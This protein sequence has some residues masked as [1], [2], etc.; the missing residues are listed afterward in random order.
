MDDDLLQV[1]DLVPN[2]SQRNPTYEPHGQTGVLSF[3]AQSDE[4]VTSPGGG[5]Y[6]ILEVDTYGLDPY[7]LDTVANTGGGDLALTDAQVLDFANLI[8][9]QVAAG[10]TLEQPVI[11]DL[12]NSVAGVSGSGLAVGNSRASVNDILRI[13]SGEVYKIPAGS[14]VVRPGGE[15]PH[16]LHGFF[17]TP[18]N[19]IP[20]LTTGP[21]GR[22]GGS[23][24]Q[25]VMSP[26][27]RPRRCILRAPSLGPL[28]RG[29]LPLRGGLPRPISRC[30]PP[31]PGPA[32]EA[33]PQTGTQDV[34][35]RDIRPVVMGG[36]IARS[37]AVGTLA[38]F[39]ASDFQFYN[40]SFRYGVG[41]TAVAINGLEIPEDG[42]YPAVAVFT[43]TGETL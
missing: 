36:D 32:P 9:D 31:P 22:K 28:P 42:V 41:G 4:V 2:V 30:F 15:F 6:L 20:A 29:G 43:D 13:L 3:F 38:K 16:L 26:G 11:D 21:G 39:K 8:L 35:Y 10:G 5:G 25:S 14:Q 34:T 37:A 23:V 24:T 1:L 12:L 27:P 7:L 19:V 18:P 33:A 17:V 40:W